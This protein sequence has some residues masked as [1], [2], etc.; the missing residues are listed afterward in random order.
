MFDIVF[1]ILFIVMAWRISA[2]VRRESNIFVEFKQPKSLAFIVF[3]FPLGPL[4]LLVGTASVPLVGWLVAIACFLPAFVTS[5]RRVYVFERAGTDRVKAALEACQQAF[6]TALLGLIY[7]A[8]HIVLAL[9]FS[10]YA[11][12]A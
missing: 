5:R 10:A 8:V 2:R 7:I 1:T 12:D 6:G 4:A 9:A 11:P 3:L